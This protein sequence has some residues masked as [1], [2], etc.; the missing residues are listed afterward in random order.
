MAAATIAKEETTET[1]GADDD[2]PPDSEDTPA[3]EGTNVPDRV[4]SKRNKEKEEE[5][6]DDD[7][8]DSM[9]DMP[10]IVDSSDSE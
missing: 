2:V 5:D 10:D 4:G 1:N 8:D 9:G 6:D 3:S 7:D